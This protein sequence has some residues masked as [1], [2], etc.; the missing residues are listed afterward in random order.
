PGAAIF[1]RPVRDAPALLVQDAPPCNHLVL[2]QMRPSTSFCRVAGGTLSLKNARTS[3]RN[4]ISSLLKARSIGS[5]CERI[6]FYVVT[7][8]FLAGDEVCCWRNSWRESLPTDVRGSSA[9]NSTAAG[10][11]CL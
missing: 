2:R 8:S 1:L 11:S 3:S 4:A 7:R 5:S 9:T 6:N 10:N